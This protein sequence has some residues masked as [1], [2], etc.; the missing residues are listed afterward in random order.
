[1]GL[2]LLFNCAYFTNDILH[3]GCLLLQSCTLSLFFLTKFFSQSVQAY[4][5]DAFAP[6]LLFADLHLA[7]V[8]FGVLRRDGGGIFGVWQTLANARQRLAILLHCLLRFGHFRDIFRRLS[9]FAL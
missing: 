6:F 2:K 5:W 7:L 8:G 4:D 1:M 9:D 3:F